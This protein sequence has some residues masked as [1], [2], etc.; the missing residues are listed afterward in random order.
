MH[1]ALVCVWEDARFWARWNY[2]FEVHLN[3]LGPVSP[4]STLNSLREH[5]WTAAAVAAGLMSVILHLLIWKVTFFM[6]MM[7][8]TTWVNLQRIMLSLKKERENRRRKWQSTLV[9]LPGRYHGPKSLEGCSPW[10]HMTAH[11]HE[12]GGGRRVDS[13]KQR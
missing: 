3:C 8:V 6:H 11:A 9:F 5:R 4:F 12:R 13:N 1:L 7:H 10:G 2:S